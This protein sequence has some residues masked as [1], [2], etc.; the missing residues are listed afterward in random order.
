MSLNRLG[1]NA[2]ALG[3]RITA[4]IA[5]V[6]VLRFL[7][8]RATA[9]FSVGVCL[10]RVQDQRR[11]SD[12]Y[13]QT[14]ATAKD[15]DTFLRIAATKVESATPRLSMCFDDGYED[16]AAYVGSRAPLYPTVEWAFFVCPEK[17]KKKAGFRWD[18]YELMG[19]NKGRT[20]LRAALRKDLAVAAEN[21]RADLKEVARHPSFALASE[22][23]CKELQKL[24]NVTVGNHTNTH[25]NLATLPRD[26]SSLDLRSSTHDFEAAFGA[27]RQFAFPFGVP[28]LHFSREHVELLRSLR[29]P[30]MWSTEERPYR[31]TERG[32]GS[33][34]PRMV[35][36]G[37]WGGKAMAL[38]TSYCALRHRL[39]RR[40]ADF[41][42]S[43]VRAEK[44]VITSSPAA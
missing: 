21:D 11:A 31:A 16:S 12:P 41:A 30:I 29:N 13:P 24:P 15:I 42:S 23:R 10:H 43:G 32:P 3:V 1:S 25:F 9:G 39:G 6:S 7:Y 38:W 20:G 8:Q 19:A 27:M 5:P 44:P 2:V 36:R 33:V 22:E 34:L 14:T 40:A 26:E 37:V 35:F 18:L 17:I 28:G 4:A